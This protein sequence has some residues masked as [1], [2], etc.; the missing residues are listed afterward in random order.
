MPINGKNL[1]LGT[2]NPTI[3]KSSFTKHY[4]RIHFFT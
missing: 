3:A 2:Y 4:G 1:N